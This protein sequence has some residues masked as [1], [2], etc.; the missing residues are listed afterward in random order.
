MIAHGTATDLPELLEAVRKRLVDKTGLADRSV[1]YTMLP[2]AELVKTPPVNTFITL[3][4]HG[5]RGIKEI[6]AGAGGA[7]YDGTLAV[8]VWHRLDLDQWGHTDA[9][10]NSEGGALTVWLKVLAALQLWTPTRTSDAA[11]GL[12]IEPMRNNPGFDFPERKPPGWGRLDSAWDVK[13]VHRLS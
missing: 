11:A 4:L 8:Q 6:V 3:R 13:F 9:W 1:F 12:L 7:A 5:F 2:D 10:L